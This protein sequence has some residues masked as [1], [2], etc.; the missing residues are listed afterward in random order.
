MKT[1]AIDYG[2][3]HIGLAISDEIG[4]IAA[5]LPGLEVKDDAEALNKI[6]KTVRLNNVEQILMGIPDKGPIK[7]EITKFV[8]ELKSTSS[9]PVITW[10]EDFSSIQSEK[11]TSKKFKH[12]KSHSEVARIILQEYLDAEGNQI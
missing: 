11:G 4:I 3:R 8:V 5:K 6:M 7:E 1:L 9:L 12:E 2:K 10:N